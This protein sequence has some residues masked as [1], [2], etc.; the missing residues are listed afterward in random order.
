MRR[1]LLTI[2]SALSLVLCVA[3]VGLWV[4]SYRHHDMVIVRHL[5]LQPGGDQ[6]G[7]FWSISFRASVVYFGH[8]RGA[9]STN[10]A[11]GIHLI[12]DRVTPSPWDS[13]FNTGNVKWQFLRLAWVDDT[14]GRDYTR[15]LTIP[16][17]LLVCLFA[18]PP[19]AWASR[20]RELRKR[21]AKGLCLQC[22]YDLR[23]T[24]GRCPECGIAPSKLG[25]GG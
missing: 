11:G 14:R 2:A 23:A 20:W 21:T 6:V 18:A 17:W 15:F 16:T 22:G 7:T 4:R 9:F 25:R 8:G 24:H 3:S 1:R 12:S 10:A 19:I 13:G 5:E